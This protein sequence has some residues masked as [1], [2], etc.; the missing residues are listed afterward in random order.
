MQARVIIEE[1]QDMNL[2][3]LVSMVGSYL[4]QQLSELAIKY[5]TLI[6]NV[7]GQGT[8]MAFDCVDVA[9]RDKM[10]VD[11]R[12]RGVHMGGCGV[13]SIRLRPML[14]FGGKHADIFLDNLEIVCKGQQ[15]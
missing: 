12:N 14:I 4:H 5:P 7:R 15:E 3:H 11:L 1:I 9:T 8:Y 10:L 13:K 6:S 2:L